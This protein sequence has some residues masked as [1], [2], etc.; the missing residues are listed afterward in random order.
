MKQ[1]SIHNLLT[2]LQHYIVYKNFLFLKLNKIHIL[3]IK[4]YQNLIF[5]II[6]IVNKDNNS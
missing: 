3:M 4:N 1:I 5:Q 6:Y 2:I